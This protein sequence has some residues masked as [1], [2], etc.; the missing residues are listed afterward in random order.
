MNPPTAF[1]CT[2]SEMPE[3]SPQVGETWEMLNPSTNRTEQAVIASFTPTAV[4]LISRLGRVLNIPHRSFELSWKFVHEA[5]NHTCQ[6]CPNVGYLLV[7]QNGTWGWV[8]ENHL[9]PEQHQ[10][11]LPGDRPTDLEDVPGG[12][13]QCPNC[14]RALQGPSFEIESFACRRC[15]ECNYIWTLLLG[16]GIPED[17]INL[18]EMI[19]D[20]ADA[21]QGRVLTIEAL[22]GS[23]ALQAIQ[24][25]V[26]SRSWRNGA[27]VSGVRVTD[28]GQ[29]FGSLSVVVLGPSGQAPIQT[30]G[31]LPNRGQVH[32]EEVAQEQLAK[33]GTSTR[34]PA[35]G[36]V[37]NHNTAGTPAYVLELGTSP[38]GDRFVAFRSEL[39]GTTT[40]LMLADF[41]EVY[42]FQPVEAPCEKGDELVRCSDDE[43]W[44]AIEVLPDSYEV[45]LRNKAGR[46]LPVSYHDIR[47]HYRVLVRKSAYERL[48]DNDWSDL[49]PDD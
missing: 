17:G 34:L 11:R 21:F 22:V 29:R 45:V 38:E 18:S 25:A 40:N 10:V 33:M 12:M 44:H 2:F 1:R 39:K 28:V 31:G 35:T 47:L 41:L 32:N 16:R 27:H 23:V 9:P 14:G 30:L 42:T 20:V 5:G 19:I 49:D 37:W 4:R 7:Q 8:C 3:H 36:D 24:R 46:N 13:N 6:H 43:L 48:L 26:G 15:R